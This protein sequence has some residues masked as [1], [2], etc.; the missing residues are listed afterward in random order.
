MAELAIIG[1]DIQE[2]IGTAIALRLLSAGTLPLWVGEYRRGGRAAGAAPYRS[3]LLRS[4]RQAAPVLPPPVLSHWVHENLLLGCLGQGRGG[5]RCLPPLRSTAALQTPCL[6]WP[7]LPP[8]PPPPLCRRGCGGCDR[9]CAAVPGAL[10]YPIPG[11]LLPAVG[12]GHVHQLWWVGRHLGAAPSGW[13]EQLVC[14]SVL[15]RGG[16][17]GNYS[18]GNNA[19]HLSLHCHQCS[20]LVPP[21]ATCFLAPASRIMRWRAVGARGER[22]GGGGGCTCGKGGVHVWEGAAFVEGCAAAWESGA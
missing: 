21:Q 22:S 10:G 13:Q 16:Q 12:C 8:P 3:S 20:V 7:G 9:L 18:C 15:M 19:H 2:V 14:S 11:T 6:A 1:S 4:L 5:A 17:Q